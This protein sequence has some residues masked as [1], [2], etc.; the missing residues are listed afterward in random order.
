VLYTQPTSKAICKAV[1][2][3]SRRW[4]IQDFSGMIVALILVVDP[5][6]FRPISS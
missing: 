4:Q 2:L 3:P 5:M 1:C 6:F